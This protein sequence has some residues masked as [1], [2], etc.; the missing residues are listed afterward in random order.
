MTEPK[1]I[2]LPKET[3][4]DKAVARLAAWLI[5]PLEAADDAHE[6]EEDETDG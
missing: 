6:Y 2:P 1:P 5:T 4:S 3:W